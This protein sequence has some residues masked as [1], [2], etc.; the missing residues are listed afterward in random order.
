MTKVKID[1][2]PCGFVTAVEAR[3]NEDEEVVVTVKSGCAAVQKL[4]EAAGDTFDP[5]ELCLCKPGQDPLTQLAPQYFPVHSGCPV[6][7]GIIKCVE[8]EAG[9]ALRH[10]V[11]IRFVEE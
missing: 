6:I 8:A 10:D 5:M 3:A 9:L 2:G 1:P 7:S 11:S 4:M